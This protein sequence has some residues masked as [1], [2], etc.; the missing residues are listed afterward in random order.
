VLDLAAGVAVTGGLE[1]VLLAS[2][3]TDERYPLSSDETA[4]P[5]PGRGFG[6]SLDAR[7]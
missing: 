7:W 1:V 2:N 3:L 5:A 4:P 6:L